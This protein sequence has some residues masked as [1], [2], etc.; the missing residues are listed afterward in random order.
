[1]TDDAAL[2]SVPADESDDLVV[3]RGTEEC[4][5]NAK[6]PRAKPRPKQSMDALLPDLPPRL[7]P[8]PLAD[9][10]DLP[11]PLAPSTEPIMMPP[12]PLADDKVRRGS[13]GSA[14]HCFFCG[15]RIGCVC[16]CLCDRE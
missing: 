1:M 2:V 10:P 16:V 7:A 5:P 15:W 6:R 9:L 13:D 3:D 14:K 8:A 4:P 12:A 11:P